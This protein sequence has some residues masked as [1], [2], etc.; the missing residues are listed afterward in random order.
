MMTQEEYMEVKALRAAG[1]TITQIAQQVGHHPATVSGWLRNGGPPAK[2]ETPVADLV[3][4]EV[5][6]AR[7]AGMLT[8]NAQLQASSIM[9][10]IAAEGFAGSYQSVTRHLREVRGPTRG[11][12]ATAKLTMPIVTGPGEEFQFDWSDCNRWAR[13]W[14]WDHELHCFG[15]VLCWSRIKRWWFA[16]TID[17]PHTLEGLA[18][19]FD[20]I[21]GVPG[22]GRTDRMG[23]LG[24]SR[25]PVFV[26]HPIALEFARHYGFGLKACDAGDAKRKGKIER[27]FRD[28]KAGFLAEMDLDPPTDVAELNRR[29]EAWLARHAHAVVHGTTKVTPDERFRVESAVLGPLPRVR[30]DTARREPRRVGRIPLIEWDT[31][32]YST[33]PEVITEMIEVRVPVAA[34]IL[35][36]RFAGRLVAVHRLAPPGSEPQWLPEHRAAAEAIAM[37][38]RHLRP[39]TDTAPASARPVVLELG[40]GDYDV[41]APDLADY[42]PIAPGGC[43]CLG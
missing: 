11:N 2:R 41:E 4:D 6:Q 26:W 3:I 12:S 36:L 40:A 37:G 24:R 18:G 33:P 28:L 16:D 35:E 43:G 23:Q 10:V 42:E 20:A 19:W 27:P 5:W 30:F 38:R 13:R 31:V 7:I 17:Q 32:F 29:A 9:R 21:G 14:G 39:V 8:H 1:W 34:G 22:L 25:G 15:T